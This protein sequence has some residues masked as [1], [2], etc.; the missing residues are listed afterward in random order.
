[1]TEQILKELRTEFGCPAFFEVN[2]QRD[3]LGCVAQKTDVA[4]RIHDRYQNCLQERKLLDYD[5]LL[6]LAYELLTT[7]PEIAR[8]L[9]E[10][11]RLV[12]VDEIQDTQDLQ[13]AIL[14]ALSRTAPE[15][16]TFFLVGDPDQSIYESLGA[17]AKSGK[18][19]AQEF[20]LGSIEELGLTGNY[21]STQ[22]II[23]FYQSFRPENPQILS[24]TDYAKEKGLVTLHNQ[25][26]DKDDLPEAIAQLIVRAVD[27]RVP[28]SEICVLAPPVVAST[29]AGSTAYSASSRRRVRRSWH[30]T[31]SLPARQL[32]VQDC[33]A[34]SDRPHAKAL[35]NKNEVGQGGD[36]RSTGSLRRGH[37]RGL[38]HASYSPSID[39]QHR[40]HERGWTRVP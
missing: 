29:L 12:C 18:E 34:P 14:A 33:A 6:F 37:P 20:G 28:S 23:D 24:L 35:P 22:R 21:R 5:D 39:K 15:P 2:L 32:L 3:R 19:I 4:Q 7:I 16:M 27:A 31:S 10:I 17:V 40:S 9:A 8:T 38:S 13:Y 25:V 1:V 36:S 26:F 30:V 11:I